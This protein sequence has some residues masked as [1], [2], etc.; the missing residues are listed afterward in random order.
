MIPPPR[1]DL[2]VTPIGTGLAV[3][4]PVTGGRARLGPE[5]AAVWR[6]LLDG[7]RHPATLLAALPHLTPAT[8]RDRLCQL[9]DALLLDGPRWAAQR[10]LF[11]E[12][13]PLPPAADLPLRLDPALRHQCV[14]CG[15]SCTGVHVGPVPDT[16]RAAVERLGLWRAVPGATKAD[17]AFA[18][19][20]GPDGPWAMMRRVGEA[21]FAL[22]ADAGCALHAA[23][24]SAAKPPICRQFPYTFTRGPDAVHVGLQ[25]ECARFEATLPA[26]AERPVA[27]IEAELTA[28]VAEGAEVFDLPDPVPI[29]AGLWRPRARVAPLIDAL[30]RATGARD[31]GPPL[32]ELLEPLWTGPTEAPAP[33]R[34]FAYWPDAAAP[35]PAAERVRLR[36]A[37]DDLL[38]RLGEAAD[39]GGRPLDGEATA[40]VR[41]AVRRWTGRDDLGRRPAAPWAHPEGHRLWRLAWTAHVRDLAIVRQRDLAAGLGR[42]DLL[43][44]LARLIASDAAATRRADRATVE[45]VN[46]GLRFASRVLRMAPVDALL[47]QH[48]FVLRGAL[49]PVDDVPPWLGVPA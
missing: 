13:E 39:Q 33:W 43:T 21:C 20:Q 10:A 11:E 2:R 45:D 42:L 14:R 1:P 23:E 4:D 24:G 28:L 12:A 30:A 49:L 40:R 27:A 22:R 19:G 47:R 5:S 46:V 34:A 41:T 7:H 3:D 32:A 38:G 15:A 35:D 17:D 18:R 26:G 25:M 9:D 8:I 36:D 6:A 31:P 48:A 16:T 44:D 29:A 37:L